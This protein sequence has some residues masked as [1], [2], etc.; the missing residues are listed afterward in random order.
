MFIQGQR[1]IVPDGRTGTITATSEGALGELLIHVYTDDG[2]T[3][4]SFFPHELRPVTEPEVVFSVGDEVVLARENPIQST[5][6]IMSWTKGKYVVKWKSE[7]GSTSEW[8]KDLLLHKRK[9]DPKFTPGD[10]VYYARKAPGK[11]PLGVVTKIDWVLAYS[12]KF[13]NTGDYNVVI[14]WD[15]G[16]ESS[17]DPLEIGRVSEALEALRQPIP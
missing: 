3:M 16:V 12:T 6:I 15:N 10:R 9:P 14:E 17:H 5:G 8:G 2:D 7:Y 13:Y 4:K 1:V 11:F